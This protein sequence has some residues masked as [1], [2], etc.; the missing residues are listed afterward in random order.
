MGNISR[1]NMLDDA[2]SSGR[3][4]L[5]SSLGIRAFNFSVIVVYSDK[6]ALDVEEG[7]ETKGKIGYDFSLLVAILKTVPHGLAV[8]SL[9]NKEAPGTNFCV[10]KFCMEKSFCLNIGIAFFLI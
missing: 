6:F 5:R 3:F 7:V 8:R 2:N 1:E 9:F 4:V 10:T